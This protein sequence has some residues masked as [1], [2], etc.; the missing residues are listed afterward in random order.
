MSVTHI[1]TGRGGGHTHEIAHTRAHIIL[2]TALNLGKILQVSATHQTL[3]RQ[4]QVFNASRLRD[5]QERYHCPVHNSH[6]ACSK[7]DRKVDDAHFVNSR[8]GQ[9]RII[10]NWMCTVPLSTM[11]VGDAFRDGGTATSVSQPVS[12]CCPF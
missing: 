1:M 2:R 6:D 9:K 4:G 7:Q 10:G 3:L 5:N 8:E 11:E 12:V